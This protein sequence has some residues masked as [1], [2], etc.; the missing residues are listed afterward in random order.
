[1]L[2]CQLARLLACRLT[3]LWVR[4]LIARLICSLPKATLRGEKTAK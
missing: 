3:Y 4:L 2:V 1:L